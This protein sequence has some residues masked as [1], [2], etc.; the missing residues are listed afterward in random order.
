MRRA[1]SLLNARMG[2]AEHRSCMC[3]GQGLQGAGERGGWRA[4]HRL[5]DLTVEM[6][7]GQRS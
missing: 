4:E 3:A 1:F 2:Q 7:G 6:R 5:E